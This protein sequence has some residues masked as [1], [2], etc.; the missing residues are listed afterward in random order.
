MMSKEK[1]EII[2]YDDGRRLMPKIKCPYCN[3]RLADVAN[4]KLR[5]ESMIARIS[6]LPVIDFIF[7]CPHCHK[8]VALNLKCLHRVSTPAVINTVVN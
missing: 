5:N 2:K 7:E 3:K 6:D 8:M 4:S 1:I